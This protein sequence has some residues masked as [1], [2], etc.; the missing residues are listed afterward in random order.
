M[1]SLQS[2]HHAE[3][4][5]GRQAVAVL[6]RLGLEL[7]PEN[8]TVITLLLRGSNDDLKRSFAQLRRPISQSDMTE[9]TRQFLPFLTLA[10]QTISAAMALSQSLPTVHHLLERIQSSLSDFGEQLAKTQSVILAVGEPAAPPVAHVLTQLSQSAEAQAEV[11]MRALHAIA[12]WLDDLDRA[13]DPLAATYYSQSQTQQKIQAPDENHA[14]QA[15]IIAHP[16]A[17]GLSHGLGERTEMMSRLQALHSGE[18]HLD[19]YSLMLCRVTGLENYRTPILRKARDF[20]LDTLG[21]QTSRMIGKQDSA[22]WMSADEMGLLLNSDNEIHL[23]DVSQRLRRLV[24]GAFTHARRTVKDLTPVGARFGCALALGA[25]SPA[26]LY[27]S[28]RLALQRAELTENDGLLIN[29][30]SPSAATR[31]YPAIYGRR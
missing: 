21:R 29:R 9:L 26:Q 10:P 8:F 11:N 1:S 5:V 2:E 13:G 24:D 31:R 30:V 6:T 14:G 19:G 17:P 23:T 3:P 25:A 7:T 12:G 4:S 20:L 18:Q 15:N 22:C 16:L 28:A 27:S